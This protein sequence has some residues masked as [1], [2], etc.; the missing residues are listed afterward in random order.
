MKLMLGFNILLLLPLLQLLISSII[1][2]IVIIM[3]LTMMTTTTTTTT[4]A[5]TTAFPVFAVMLFACNWAVALSMQLRPLICTVHIQYMG[6]VSPEQ[7]SDFWKV[8]G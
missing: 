6:A 7:P 4:T 3:M 8:L 5:T 1:I 2:I